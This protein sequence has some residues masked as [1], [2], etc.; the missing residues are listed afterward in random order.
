MSVAQY[1]GAIRKGKVVVWDETEVVAISDQEWRKYRREYRRCLADKS[2]VER[3]KEEFTASVEAKTKRENEALKAEQEKASKQA[4]EAT[5]QKQSP[6]EDTSPK[7]KRVA[8]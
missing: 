6:T 8:R 2:L 1:I 4:E 7:G 5:V 3:T